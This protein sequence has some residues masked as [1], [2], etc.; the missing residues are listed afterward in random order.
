[1]GI[2]NWFITKTR[3][4]F[5]LMQDKAQFKKRTGKGSEF[6]S[7]TVMHQ[8]QNK[9]LRLTLSTQMFLIL[10]LFVILKDL[11]HNVPHEIKIAILEPQA[12]GDLDTNK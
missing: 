6:A 8:E 4:R 12:I 11:S 1:M 5:F 7:S 3:G 2:I 10:Q 9:D